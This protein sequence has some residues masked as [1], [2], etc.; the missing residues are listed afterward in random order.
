MAMRR[1][2]TLSVNVDVEQDEVLELISDDDLI[3]E[4]GARNAGRTHLA[5]VADA[6]AQIKR[7]DT[8]DAITTLERE[9][10]PKWASVEDSEAALRR[11][12]AVNDNQEAALSGAAG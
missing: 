4:L 2:K 7:G 9:F 12:R 11:A 10:W 8:H 1:L 3:A 6:I 5:A